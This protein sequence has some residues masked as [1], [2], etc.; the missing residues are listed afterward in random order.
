MSVWTTGCTIALLAV[1][2]VLA[3]AQSELAPDE[4][5]RPTERPGDAVVLLDGASPA[6]ISAAVGEAIGVAPAAEAPAPASPRG[7]AG[8]FRPGGETP[9]VEGG[10]GGGS[11][12]AITQSI[13]PTLRPDDLETTARAEATRNTP[14]RIAQP[15][16]NNGTL[17]GVVGLQGEEIEPITGRINGCG[18]PDAVRLRV[19]HGITLTTPATINCT[20]AQSVSEW[21]LDADE[22]IGNTGGGIANLRVVASYACRSRNSRGGAR[23]SEHATGNAIDIAGIG[24]QNGSELSVL[25]D[26]RSGNA[27]IMRNL[28][29]AACG[30]FGTVLGPE[31]DRFHQDHFHFDVASHRS[32]AFCR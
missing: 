16:R 28:H 4:S 12:L 22:I 19:V 25:S 21:V 27:S 23:L 9:P 17:C 2:P 31:S 30:T 20:T 5:V 8:L 11:L 14:A 15:G 10:V 29:S 7:L 1:M 18:I 6:A 24:L 26:W 13:R 3:V 32:G